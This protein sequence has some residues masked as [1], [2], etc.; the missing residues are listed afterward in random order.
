MNI[1]MAINK[2][3]TLNSN[4]NGDKSNNY[5]PNNNEKSKNGKSK[6]KDKV[7]K[8]RKVH[9]AAIRA[10]QKEVNR[11]LG[12][13]LLGVPEPPK[14]PKPVSL[15]DMVQWAQNENVSL[16]D[17]SKKMKGI[18]KL[19]TMN[20]PKKT[21][22]PSDGKNQA[23]IGK[24]LAMD[25][26]FVGV[27]KLRESAL[28]RVS[29]VNYHGHVVLDEYVRPEERVTDWRTWVSGVTPYH[30]RKAITFKEAQEKVKVLLEGRILVGHAIQNDLEAL[31]LKHP[32]ED[33]RDTSLLSA[34]RKYA[35]GKTPALKKL[36]LE[37]L[38]FC[39]QAGDHSSVEDS[40]TTMLLYR[41]RKKDFENGKR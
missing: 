6:S 27:G 31:K 15:W 35:G 32:R 7:K 16:E 3:K 38:D 20:V 17:F 36:A 24:F 13:V 9:P 34:Y 29:L 10:R 37:I 33:I 8:P 25:C 1:D 26:E 18:G 28:A 21:S 11:F 19:T 5:K 12:S 4:K 22:A 14:K 41:L 39:I 40:R 2:E 30:M 23:D